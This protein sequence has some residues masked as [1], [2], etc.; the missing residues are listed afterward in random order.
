M[1]S[2]TIKWVFLH[3]QPVRTQRKAPIAGQPASAEFCHL[4]SGLIAEN[5]VQRMGWYDT[6]CEVESTK[7]LFMQDHTHQSPFL[8]RLFTIKGYR[9]A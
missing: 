2:P 7:T 9:D 5:P 8:G 1:C 3:H 4:L 6:L